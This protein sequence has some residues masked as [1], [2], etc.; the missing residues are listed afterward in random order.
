[1]VK[2]K[3]NDICHCG[4]GKKYKKCCMEK[5]K[6]LAMKLDVLEKSDNEKSSRKQHLSY[7]EVD[8]F[9]TDEIIA[10]LID[11]GIPFQKETF[12]ADVERFYSAEEISE[13]WFQQYRLS[14]A[15][16][17]EDFP[18]FAAWIL[19]ERLA[20]SDNLSMEQMDDLLQNGFK[21]TSQNNSVSACDEWFKLWE[22]IKYRI[23]S[24]HTTVDYLD[25]HYQGT[26]SVNNFCQDL[27]MELCKAGADNTRY[28][29]KRI[30]FCR[31]YCSFF[32]DESELNIHNMRRAIAE[33]YSKMEQYDM[34]ENELKQ[35]IEDFPNN[36][37]GYI[38]WGDVYFI[39]KKT[40]LVKA[41]SLYEKALSISTSKDDQLAVEER[42]ADLVKRL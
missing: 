35:L 12:L 28:L 23:D 25:K 4:S 39:D 31:E 10:K 14:L 34:A 3:R 18:W 40:D 1:M 13:N 11:L 6:E 2:L 8:K 26:F 9:Q 7:E 20:P 19:W 21:F 32:P 38:G 22:A 30:H 27:E 33:S 15:G 29:E 24:T 42:L 41:K 17:M 37:W 36:T 5:D 16:K